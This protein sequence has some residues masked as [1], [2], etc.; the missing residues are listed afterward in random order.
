MAPGRSRVSAFITVPDAM[1]VVRFAEEVF[2]ATP[3]RPPLLYADGTLWNAELAIGDCTILLGSA[4][5]EMVRTAFLYVHVPD[6]DATFVRALAAGATAMHEPDLRF[7]GDR[8]GGVTDM[9]GN[10]WWI[11]THV[12]DVDDEEM[13]RRAAAEEAGR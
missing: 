5:G 9:D 12:E 4:T 2:D 8:D 10:I 11:A 13:A 6:A 1:R 3:V 7:Y